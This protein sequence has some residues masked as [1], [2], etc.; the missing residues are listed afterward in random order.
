MS[1]KEIALNYPIAYINH[2]L[3]NAPFFK[4]VQKGK[5]EINL[6]INHKYS[7]GD[8]M[9]I[10]AQEQLDIKDEDLFLSILAITYISFRGTLIDSSSELYKDL[11]SNFETMKSIKITTTRYELLKEL[12]ISP[13]S[14]TSI[15]WV[16]ASLNRLRSTKFILNTN[17]LDGEYMS[18]LISFKISTT[19]SNT[20]IIEIALNTYICNNFLQSNILKGGIIPHN[21]QERMSLKKEI[22]R[23]LH[24]YLNA[25]VNV[26]KSRLFNINTLVEKLY[27][28]DINTINKYNKSKKRK[29]IKDGLVEI[30]NLELW[31]IDFIASDLVKIIRK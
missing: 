6:I 1:T 26:K 2:I 22:S 3:Q 14:T 29:S 28:V 12:N 13:Q 24:S 15:K 8:S 16:E 21:M 9:T 31:E 10:F 23:A 18:R 19:S 7:N 27:R 25:L 5:R 17:K 30:N 20:K 11:N 4:P